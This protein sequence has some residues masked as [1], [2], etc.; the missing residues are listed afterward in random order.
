MY[1]IEKITPVYSITEAITELNK[2]PEALI[3]AGGSD[4]LIKI[5]EG[6]LAGKRFIS[7]REIKNL[8][9]ITLEDN[10]TIC[11]R[12]LSTFSE[13][14]ENP[15][16]LSKIP[17]LA[18]AA[19]QV[20][21]PQIRNIGTIGGNISNGV[22]SADT[23]TSLC[24]LNAIIEI[25]GKNDI[26]Y[27]PILDYYVKAGTVCLAHDELCTAIRINEKDY[28]HYQGH[29]IKYA[30]R[31]AMDIATLGCAVIAKIIKKNNELILEDIRI[32]FGV[33]GPIPLR[34]FKT[35]EKLKGLTI[36]DTLFQTLSDNII[37]DINPRT[38][39]RASK[40]FR[41]Q[42]A[43]ELPVRALKHI[44]EGEKTC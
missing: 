29:Y 30:M 1:D 27:V 6:K 31:R 10:N 21:G 44:I 37:E 14:A 9:G 34:C 42:L 20:G 2:D 16:I 22:T 18:H 32:A 4:A 33:A 40:E 41:I 38:S 7:I 12:P 17:V 35:E 3:I 24:G 13:I 26:R 19:N 28:A 5:R 25:Q 15:I 8:Q 23:A 43:R 11:I 36:N 39:W